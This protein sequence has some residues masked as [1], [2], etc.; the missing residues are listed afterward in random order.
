MLGSFQTSKY[1]CR[2][3]STPYRSTTCRVKA[4]T[5]S[6]HRSYDF[7]GF[8]SGLYQK[9]CGFCEAASALGMKLSSTN[10]RTPFSSTPS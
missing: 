4:P 3:S 9:G 8:G 1:H 2:T 5:S 10:G 6:P 7:G